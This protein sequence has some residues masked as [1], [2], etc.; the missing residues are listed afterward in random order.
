MNKKQ[1]KMLKRILLAAGM[2]IVCNIIPVTGALR[3][4]LFL[5]IYL[6]IGYD[7]LRKAGLG[8]RNRQVFD[9]ISSWPSL[10]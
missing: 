3:L 2:L 7:I 8:I 10:R 4:A 9:R 6:V 1:K 5:A